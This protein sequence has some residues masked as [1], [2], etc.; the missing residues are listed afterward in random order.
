MMMQMSEDKMKRGLVVEYY[1]THRVT[2][3]SFHGWLILPCSLPI[4]I[5]MMMMKGGHRQYDDHFQHR[6][7]L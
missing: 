6:G 7:V 2:R 4:H 5:T 1:T 3:V